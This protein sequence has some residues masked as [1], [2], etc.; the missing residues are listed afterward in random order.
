[1]LNKTNVLVIPEV[2]VLFWMFCKRYFRMGE[3]ALEM[4]SDIDFYIGG[5]QKL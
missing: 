3:F 1:M 4:C 2:I 5:T